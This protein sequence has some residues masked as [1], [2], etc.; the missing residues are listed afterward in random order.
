MSVIEPEYIV[1]S[2]PDSNLNRT[3]CKL[4]YDECTNIACTP[5]GHLFCWECI[6][7]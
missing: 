3:V 5:C 2:K 1:P 7:K 4:C 6:M